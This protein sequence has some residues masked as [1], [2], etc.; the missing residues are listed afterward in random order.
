MA[1]VNLCPECLRIGVHCPDHPKIRMISVGYRKARP[2]RQAANNRKWR[3]FLNLFVFPEE[4]RK[5]FKVINP[6]ITDVQREAYWRQRE[7]E[8]R[9]RERL[10]EIKAIR[11]Q[12]QERFEQEHKERKEEVKPLTE[13]MLKR[14]NSQLNGWLKEVKIEPLRIV[15]HEVLADSSLVMVTLFLAETPEF[16]FE[17]PEEIMS[18]ITAK[19]SH[20]WI[21]I[22][23]ATYLA[24]QDA[25]VKVMKRMQGYEENFNK[26]FKSKVIFY[27]TTD[28]IYNEIRRVINR[29]W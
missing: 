29:S 5:L 1:S 9:E 12:Q 18:I 17:I 28:P 7:E 6:K 14:F 24:Y 26:C 25:V 3:E 21:D 10:E 15:T 22:S 4:E 11:Q 23:E 13:R 2:P 19:G 16:E 8:H 20:S 27:Y